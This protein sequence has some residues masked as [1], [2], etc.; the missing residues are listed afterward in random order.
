MLTLLNAITANGD[1][2][3][4]ALNSSFP[5]T[6]EFIAFGTFGG[7]TVKFWLSCHALRAPGW[8]KPADHRRKIDRVPA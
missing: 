8:M 1:G 2:T 7:G 4:L 3:A 5:L 6:A